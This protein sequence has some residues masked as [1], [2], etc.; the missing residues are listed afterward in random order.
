[1]PRRWQ[2][3]QTASSG[4]ANLHLT[5][6]RLHSQQLSVPFRAFLRFAWFSSDRSFIVTSSGKVDEG[7]PFARIHEILGE[8]NSGIRLRR[9]SVSD[10]LKKS[11][12]CPGRILMRRVSGWDSHSAEFEGRADKIPCPCTH[13]TEPTARWTPAYLMNCLTSVIG[14]FCRCKN[15]NSHSRSG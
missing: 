4:E 1:V 7:R 14:R 9:N 5:F 10:E 3:I 6:L 2:V 8:R 15:T 11:Q 13:S 12:T